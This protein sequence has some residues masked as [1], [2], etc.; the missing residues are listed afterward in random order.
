[1]LEIRMLVRLLGIGCIIGVTQMG[2]APFGQTPGETRTVTYSGVDI[3]KQVVE[4]AHFQQVIFDNRRLHTSE[5]TWVFIDGDGNAWLRDGLASEDPTPADPLALRLM[6]KTT[7]PAIY[8]ARPCT[9]DLVRVDPKC[10]AV[11]WT[12]DRY[13][14]PVIQSMHAAL[15]ARLADEPVVL[16]GFSGGGVLALHLADR[17]EN[18][19]GVITLAANLD[20]ANWAE[21]HG[22][23]AA[24]SQRSVPLRFP[25]RPDSGP[26]VRLH[27]FGGRD[28]N[29]PYSLSAELLARDSGAR[30]KVFGEADHDCCWVSLWPAVVAE[31]QQLM[32]DSALTRASSSVR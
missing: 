9:F 17:V 11:V 1:M 7:A 10:S 32:E 19:V 15:A 13:S 25:L 16:V 22:F 24:L 3:D 27:V 2:C 12:V 18:T 31:F 4:T 29:A 28:L 8:L 30:I 21:H 26:I 23:T 5:T 14:E 6:L 20:V